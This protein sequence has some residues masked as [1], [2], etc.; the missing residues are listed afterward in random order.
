MDG[1]KVSPIVR[2]FWA[3]MSVVTWDMELTDY[4]IMSVIRNFPSCVK[5]FKKNVVACL[6][7][8]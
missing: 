7:W 8:L 1:A 2:L 4:T 5:P 3:M 6:L